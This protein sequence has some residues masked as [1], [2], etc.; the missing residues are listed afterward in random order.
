VYVNKSMQ[1]KPFYFPNNNYNLFGVL[2]LPGT[3]PVTDGF[4][5]CHPFAEEK[6]WTH[7]VFV[8]FARELTK[9]GYAV[10]RFDY[11]GHGD[12]DG[13]FEESTVDS[14]LAD[15]NCA[16]NQLKSEIPSLQEIG[17]LGLRFGATLAGLVAG[18]RD[19]IGKLIL[20]EP[21]VDGS[22]YMIEVLRTNLTTQLAVFGRV[23]QKREKLIEQMKSGETVNVD[24]YEISYDLFEQG[25]KIELLDNAL[26][27]NGDTLIVQLGKEG[28]MPREELKNLCIAYVN[29]DLQLAN[30]EPFW[31]EIKRYYGRAD[32]LYQVTNNWLKA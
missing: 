13:E 9:L 11:M 20:W 18:Q 17:L 2:H 8:S 27:F 21:V 14:R 23:T 3:N 4:V 26:G 19:D 29:C 28:Q 22:R 6:L 15:I 10:L 7:R 24:G 31:R 5:F 12:S 16:I 1:E 30:E 25:S 32:D